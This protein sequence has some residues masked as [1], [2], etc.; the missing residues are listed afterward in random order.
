[1]NEMRRLIVI[2]EGTEDVSGL[3]AEPVSHID[4]ITRKPMVSYKIF[5]NGEQIDVVQGRYATTPEEAIRHYLD[6]QEWHAEQEQ[7]RQQQPVATP[8]KRR[9]VREPRPD[10]RVWIVPP[11]ARKAIEDGDD[12]P[13]DYLYHVTSWPRARRI[14]RQGL[15]VNSD[16]MF[17]NYGY[18]T[19]GRIF[20]TERDGVRFWEWRVGDHLQH[21]YDRP[22]PVAVLKVRRSDVADLL[23][24]DVVGTRDSRANA[25]FIEADFG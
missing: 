19:A 13:D 9:R 25:Y 12:A 23:Q 16:P 24:P 22:P 10:I 2:A 6:M 20:L 3:T 1:M 17:S 14:I 5:R 11:A 8:K 7:Q 15:Q 4:P 21:N 18:N